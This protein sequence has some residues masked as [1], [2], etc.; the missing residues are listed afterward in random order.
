MDS[1]KNKNQGLK[2]QPFPSRRFTKLST[3]TFNGANFKSQKT[4]ILSPHQSS[5]RVKKFVAISISHFCIGIFVY[6]PFQPSSVVHIAHGHVQFCLPPPDHSFCSHCSHCSQHKC[7]PNSFNPKNL[8]LIFHKQHSWKHLLLQTVDLRSSHFF[9]IS[10]CGSKKKNV[11]LCTDN[12]NC[13]IKWSDETYGSSSFWL[14][15]QKPRNGK[16]LNDAKHQGHAEAR[17]QSMTEQQNLR[18]T[19]T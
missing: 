17:E 11:H 16:K 19:C 7:Y 4:W 2:P 5:S 1:R 12:E 14:S 3:L 8:A 10:T 18:E 13:Y 6:V 9:I 15:A